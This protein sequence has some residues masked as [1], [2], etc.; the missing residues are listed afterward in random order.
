MLI[1][2]LPYFVKFV[3]VINN[4]DVGYATTDIEQF[5]NIQL[6]FNDRLTDFVAIRIGYI[7]SIKEPENDKRYKITDIAIKNIV[8]DT[9]N[10]NLGSDKEDI[11]DEYMIGL[12]KKYLFSIFI[13]MDLLETPNS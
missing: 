7:L 11:K 3:F 8:E 13:Y 5:K 2:D 4:S 1:K 10:V 9:K 6:E 12:H